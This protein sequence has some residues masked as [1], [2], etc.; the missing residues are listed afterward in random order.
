MLPHSDTDLL[1]LNQLLLLT[2]GLFGCQKIEIPEIG[3]PW[4]AQPETKRPE[5]HGFCFFLALNKTIPLAE[6][7]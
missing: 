2:N 5:P 1:F 6:T 3:N 4:I 7:L